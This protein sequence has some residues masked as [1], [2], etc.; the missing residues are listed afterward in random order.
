MSNLDPRLPDITEML[1]LLQSISNVEGFS[2]Q[3][4]WIWSNLQS[5]DALPFDI[6]NNGLPFI[7]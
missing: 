5:A 4:F 3:I 2:S 1:E 7:L 6:L